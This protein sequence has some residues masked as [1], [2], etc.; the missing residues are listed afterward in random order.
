MKGLAWDAFC[1]QGAQHVHAASIETWRS[2]TAWRQLCIDES[3][4]LIVTRSKTGQSM[5]NN[6]L[7]ARL[8]ADTLDVWL[9]TWLKQA[10]APMTW[11]IGPLTSPSAILEALQRHASVE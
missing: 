11:W 5:F 9:A 4:Q 7:R 3:E 10:A 6:V 1:P 2:R 8:P